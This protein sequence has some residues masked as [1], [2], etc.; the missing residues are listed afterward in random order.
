MK[1]CYWE[2]IM[3]HGIREA[4]LEP[5]MTEVVSWY[6]WRLCTCSSILEYDPRGPSGSLLGVERR[7]GC[8][9]M[10]LKPMPTII[11]M[12][13]MFSYLRVMRV[14]LNPM[15]LDSLEELRQLKS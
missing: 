10:E 9:T 2:G 11:R 6:V 15:D 14:P 4:K 5:T 7:W 13:S 3:I 12:N 1:Y 8:P